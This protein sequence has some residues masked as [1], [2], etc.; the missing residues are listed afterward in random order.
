MGYRCCWIAAKGVGLDA[1]LSAMGLVHEEDSD[2]GVYDPG[3]YA[4]VMPG[5]WL[6]VIG[7]GRDALGDVQ[8]EHA[9]KLSAGTEALHF[10]CDDTP[11]CASLAAYRD[12]REVWSLA[13]R[14]EP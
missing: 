14:L 2:E 6:V 7:D 10:F 1:A 3:H 4:V 11:M 13:L 8:P 12:G 5:G 9:Q